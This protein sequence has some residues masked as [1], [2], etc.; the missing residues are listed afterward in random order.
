M[1]IRIQ[2]PD[3]IPQA[4]RLLAAVDLSPDG[5][6]RTGGLPETKAHDP[7]TIKSAVRERYGAIAAQGGSCCDPANASPNGCGCK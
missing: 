1:T 2:K 6:D 7:E 3:D 4:G 5:L